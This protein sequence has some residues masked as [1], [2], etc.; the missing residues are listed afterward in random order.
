MVISMATMVAACASARAKP[1]RDEDSE[2]VDAILGLDRE[3]EDPPE[4][5]PLAEGTDEPPAAPPLQSAKEALTATPTSGTSASVATGACTRPPHGALLPAPVPKA[6]LLRPG[7]AK[8]FLPP[9]PP[10]PEHP[11]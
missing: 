6:C 7:T 9:P 2:R 11:L 1:T 3:P 5:G 4:P 8:L 10:K